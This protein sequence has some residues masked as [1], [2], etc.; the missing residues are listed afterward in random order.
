[1]VL[2]APTNGSTMDATPNFGGSAGTAAG[3]SDTVTVK[4]YSGTSATGTPVRTPTAIVQP[5]GTFSVKLGAAL[6]SGTYTA[7]VEQADGGGNIGRSAQ[8]TFT[9][10]ASGDPVVLSAGDIAACD[11]F[12]DEATAALLDRLPGTVATLG[13]HVYEY[14]TASDFTNCYDPTWGRH[15]ART[16]PTVGDHEYLSTSATPYFNYFG[17]AA[18][19]PTKGYY[20]YDIGSWHVVSMN[21]NCGEVPGGCFAGSPEEQWLRADLAAHPASCTLA[22]LHNPRFSSGSIHGS[23]SDYE[24]FWQALYEAGAELALSGDDHLY[25]RFAPQTPTG[26][27][28]PAG[29]IRQ[30]VVGTGGRSHYDFGPIEPNSQVRNNDTFGVLALTLHPASYEWEFV[31]EA[32][33]TF[34]DSGSTSC[35]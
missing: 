24:D 6:A 35:H 29:G 31:P 25:E 15:K 14:A 32:G 4:V 16:K 22:I 12:G 3:D 33:K 11:T 7:Q 9:V 20:S 28:D 19:D 5:A 2:K 26:A 1:V 34:T 27:W 18:A 8:S 23:Q 17:A 13:D 10:D 30:F 21:T